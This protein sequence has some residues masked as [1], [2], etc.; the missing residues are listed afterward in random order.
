MIPYSA[1]RK[2]ASKMIKRNQKWYKPFY[3]TNLAMKLNHGSNAV[4]HCDDDYSMG[5]GIKFRPN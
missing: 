5:R 4:K 2:K 3:L 1:G